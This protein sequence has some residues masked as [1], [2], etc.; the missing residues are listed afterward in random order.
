LSSNDPRVHFG[1]GD[2]TKVDGLEIHWPDGAVE[3]IGLAGVDRIFTVEEGK[4]LV[5]STA[6]GAGSQAHSAR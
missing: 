1:L 6:L 2:A 4:R 3:K 5:P